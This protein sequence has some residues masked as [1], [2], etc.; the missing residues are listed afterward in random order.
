MSSLH[1]FS[2]EIIC[3]YG[4][5]ESSPALYDPKYL[6][7]LSSNCFCILKKDIG[8]CKLVGL[9]MANQSHGQ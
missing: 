9:N 7:P 4:T 8:D 3:G 2:Q 5:V 1:F 6:F